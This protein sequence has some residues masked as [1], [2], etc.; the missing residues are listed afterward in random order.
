MIFL[1]SMQL[2]VSRDANDGYY[3]PLHLV[4]SP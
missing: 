4:L 3:S 2:E 1:G